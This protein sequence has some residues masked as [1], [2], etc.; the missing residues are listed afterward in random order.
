MRGGFP[1]RPFLFFSLMINR[2]MN[3]IKPLLD[4]AREGFATVD[5]DPA[6]K[7]KALSYLES[8][9]AAPDLKDYRPQIEWLIE[10]KQWAGLLDRFYQILPF[11]T[12]GRR[13]HVGIGPNRMNPWTLQAS[14]QGHC[15][16]LKE[17]FPGLNPIRIVLV[18]DVRRF[19]DVRKQ[20][21][22]NRPHPL[23]GLTS[24]R[25]AQLAAQ[26][27]VANGIHCYMPPLDSQRFWAT[28]ELS[29]A[30]RSLQAQGGLNISASHNPPDDNGG[31]FY[32]EQGGQPVPPDDQ[33]MADLVD[34]VTTIQ[35]L[36][37]A[38]ALR[39]GLLSFMDSALHLSYL[40]MLARQSLI[41]PVRQGECRIVY[42]PLHGV[43]AG[44]VMELLQRQHFE[45][46]PVAEQIEPNGLFP[47]V[48]SPNP[49]VPASMDQAKRLAIE[50]K[51]DLVLSTDP[52]GD[53]LGALIPMG[54]NWRFVT[55]NELCA[56]LT[57][58]K[59][60][61]LQVKGQLPRSPLVILTEVTTRL[62]SKIARHFGCQVVDHL[63]VGFKYMAD[64]LHHLETTG[65]FGEIQASP[66]DMIIA[67]EES[68][69]AMLTHQL[70]DKDA[71]GASLLLAELAAYQKRH[72]FTVLDYLEQIY[73][74]FGYHHN[75]V[76]NVVMTGILGK[77][78]MVQMLDSLRQKPLDKVAG[79]P[80]TQMIDL[81]SESSVFGPLRGE[82][83][84]SNRNVLL[85][86][87]GEQARIALR[88]SGTEPKA[89]AYVEV[90]SDSKPAAM[91]NQEWQR[92]VSDTIQRCDT[93]SLDFATQA[94]ARVGLKP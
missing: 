48:V 33:I 63:L 10:Q 40:D 64:V 68:H 67:T 45:V 52:D 59:L 28:P 26:V 46:I 56:L 55:G 16:Y 57:H 41:G 35:Q 79:C 21:A 72:G 86:R 37:W 88:P 53:R 61:Q 58:F 31:K 23:R 47:A 92:I 2:S 93:I 42:T 36:D 90:W 44:T 17:R 24:K 54:D 84:R 22:A 87:V 94:L 39:S 25:L 62:V 71:S 70:R 19:E 91:S 69:G 13:G 89:K 74:Q 5:V 85:F 82:T 29:W 73:R 43:G 12:G 1:A 14:V 51:A 8:W 50:N 15:Q 66:E 11:G 38:D 4:Q 32:N 65:R 83:D 75:Q 77:Q 7:D 80:I 27:Y 81:Q 49:E 78:M 34:Q 20:Y 3:S 9:L 30:I 6:A 18:Y 76:R 60:E